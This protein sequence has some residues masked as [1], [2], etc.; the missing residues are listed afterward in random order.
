[1]SE[2]AFAW[3]RMPMNRRGIILA[4]GSGT[5]LQPA[6]LAG[7]KQLLPVYDKPM[8]Y[9]PLSTLM[10]AGIR[11]VLVIT[12]PEDEPG[13]RR[14]LAD[15]SQWGIEIQYALQPK[16]EGLAQAFVIGADFVRGRPSCLVLG[17]N[18]IYGNGLA[19]LLLQADRERSGATV[20]GYR[21]EDPE[22]YGVVSI[23]GDGL[24]V[25][26]EEKPARPKSDL[27]VIG[28][29]FY[30]DTVVERA[31]SVKASARGEYEITDLN[32]LFLKDRALRVR[33]LGRGFA[34]F[35]AGTHA[36]LLEASQFVHTMQRRQGQLVASPEEIAFLSGW[37]DSTQLEACANRFGKTAYGKALAAVAAESA[38]RA[39]ERRAALD[40]SAILEQARSQPRRR[41][42]AAVARQ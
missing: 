5:R 20:F 40:L 16:P 1:V 30:D 26:I 10:L 7:S 12:T 22:R 23:D 15:G 6:T 17:D 36:S 35:D 33:P 29:Y 13:F 25:D 42:A 34:W 2:F 24:A 32:L 9:Y 4:G 8:I 37:I 18:L 28:L 21:V 14:L 19:E 31:A 27:A 39:V 3:G 11:E 38:L 41:R